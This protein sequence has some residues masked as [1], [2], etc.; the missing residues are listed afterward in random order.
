MHQNL[1][2]VLSRVGIALML[3]AFQTACS[4]HPVSTEPSA[5]HASPRFDIEP[6]TDGFDGSYEEAQSRLNGTSN[7]SFEL[8]AGWVSDVVRG[9]G[10]TT[11]GGQWVPTAYAYT[12]LYVANTYT[13][14]DS[15]TCRG[16]WR[17]TANV[18]KTVDCQ[19]NNVSASLSTTH[20]AYWTS[21]PQPQLNT[22]DAASCV[23]AP[24]YSYGGGGGGG[25]EGC[26][27]GVWQQWFFYVDGYA[28]DE[29]WEFT[30]TREHEWEQ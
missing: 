10:Q 2:R 14:D 23:K 22:S 24:G 1:S 16:L 5:I 4:D 15:D 25:T 30:C 7:V 6:G 29:W 20:R 19:H 26:Y 12:E 21:G 18:S 13:A 9:V 27:E 11:V 8:G 28:V 17:C 3:G